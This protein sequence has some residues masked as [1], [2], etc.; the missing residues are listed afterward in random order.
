MASLMNICNHSYDNPYNPDSPNN[1]WCM[2]DVCGLAWFRR[3]TFQETKN[4]LSLYNKTSKPALENHNNTDNPDNP[5]I[6]F[7]PQTSSP[8]NPSNPED[9]QTIQFVPKKRREELAKKDQTIQRSVGNRNRNK[10]LNKSLSVPNLEYK[11]SKQKS[12]SPAQTRPNKAMQNRKSS[13]RQL[14]KSLSSMRI[15]R[16]SNPNNPSSPEKEGQN[17]G[18]AFS[19]RNNPDSPH[20]PLNMFISNTHD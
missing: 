13:N 12:S 7:E 14:Q 3:N 15:S 1:P 10:M 4:T 8:N 2:C 11:K 18:E 16:R 6:D 20:N 5:E 17:E 19:G 9:R